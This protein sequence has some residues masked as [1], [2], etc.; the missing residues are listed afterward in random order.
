MKNILKKITTS[1]IVSSVL[2]TNSHA[3]FGVGD[4]DISFDLTAAPKKIMDSMMQN[5]QD[6]ATQWMES[7]AKNGMN[8]AAE[9]MRSCV[10]EL[11]LSSMMG[12]LGGLSID[13]PCGE[14]WSIDNPVD[15]IANSVLSD[16]QGS[17][18]NWVNDSI[19]NITD[20][21]NYV[22]SYCGKEVDYVPN[23]NDYL[24]YNQGF[25]SKIIDK[26]LASLKKNGVCGNNSSNSS[27]SSNGS[28]SLSK[29]ITPTELK[30]FTKEINN[31]NGSSSTTSNG[32][33]SSNGSSST[34]SNNGDKV[35]TTKTNLSVQ[36]GSAET[37]ANN[38][39]VSNI[40]PNVKAYKD[41]NRLIYEIMVEEEYLIKSKL[42][43]IKQKQINKKSPNMEK[44][45]E[46]LKA[47]VKVNLEESIEDTK[48]PIS[49]LTI[50]EGKEN[51][52]EGVYVEGWRSKTP[53]LSSLTVSPIEVF[54]KI[55]TIGTK[56]NAVL[57]T[58][59]NVVDSYKKSM[60]PTDKVSGT[61]IKEKDIYSLYQKAG[62]MDGDKH[63]TGKFDYNSSMILLMESTNLVLAQFKSPDST[64]RQAAIRNTLHTANLEADRI[65]SHLYAKLNKLKAK[66]DL[67]NS[68]TFKN[69]LIELQTKKENESL[70]LMNLM[71][72]EMKNLQ[73]KK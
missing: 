25:I 42:D 61:P 2:L 68:Q 52:Q 46:E 5:A 1:I 70:E 40:L 8:A 24:T 16:F 41:T 49:V 23:F 73:S 26:K 47:N 56:Y 11:D 18:N 45:I 21:G 29:K 43:D 14:V 33:N 57:K 60:F 58:N 28:S 62:I 48:M 50:V 22:D 4:M 19:D 27:N 34:S 65:I 31:S 37:V 17:I 72:V 35:T 63:F 9:S 67:L 10:S 66:K 15:Q 3:V 64:N 36:K 30:T 6:S 20:L 13:L 7:T 69:D 51:T 54:E 59:N 39:V 32:T 38:K 55:P 44:Y 12:E 53:T 71:L